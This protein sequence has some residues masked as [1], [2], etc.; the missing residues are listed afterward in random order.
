MNKDNLKYDHDKPMMNLLPLDVLY[1][2]AK[3]LTMGAKKYTPHGYR[4]VE[5]AENRYSSALLRHLTDFQQGIELD[6]ES[7]LP[8]IDHVICC[9][10]IISWHQK[11]K[12]TTLEQVLDEM[13]E[14]AMKVKYPFDRKAENESDYC[15]CKENV[16]L[17]ACDLRTCGKCGKVSKST[18]ETERE[19]RLIAEAYEAQRNGSKPIE[20]F[21]KGVD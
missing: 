3:V 11:N 9:A 6:E 16:M 8:H 4:T 2:V 5:D 12:K 18:L 14:H 10:L 21:F 17:L 7:G 1:S 19:L 15:E 13:K 20:N